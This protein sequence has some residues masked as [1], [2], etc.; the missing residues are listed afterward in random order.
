MQESA[1]LAFQKAREEVQ[2]G[3]T[4]MAPNTKFAMRV[5]SGLAFALLALMTWFGIVVP[6]AYRLP[7]NRAQ[8]AHIR[9]QKNPHDD[10]SVRRDIELLQGDIGGDIVWAV[11]GLVMTVPSGLGLVA[12]LRGRTRDARRLAA[13]M[14]GSVHAFLRENER[15][16]A[17]LQER[18]N[19][20]DRRLAAFTSSK[21]AFHGGLEEQYEAAM[22]QF[23]E[24]HD[25]LDA[26]KTLFLDG[27]NEAVAL[28]RRRL[29]YVDDCSA[30]ADIRRKLGQRKTD[31]S[32]TDT[33]HVSQDV[34]GAALARRLEAEQ[35][36][37]GM[38]EFFLHLSEPLPKQLA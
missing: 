35:A 6:L 38:P 36:E 8:L 22:S 17:D 18:C 32:W 5:L 4:V 16:A 21:H 9:E 34:A 7:A 10:Y 14:P 2:K 27:L 24:E 30:L 26:E 12:A 37:V 33:R 11:I 15:H 1:P 29:R 28:E 25:A 31:V 13:A 3:L 23:A 20:F 19:D